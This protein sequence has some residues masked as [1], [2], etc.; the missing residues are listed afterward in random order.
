MVSGVSDYKIVQE[1]SNLR[2]V[3][4]ENYESGTGVLNQGARSFEAD[5]HFA[6]GTH[7]TVIVSAS[8]EYTNPL[9]HPVEIPALF[10][11]LRPV[12]CEESIPAK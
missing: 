11:N 6:D 4:N 1:F 9:A 5:A 8:E 2:P 10:P 12:F 3:D 7:Q